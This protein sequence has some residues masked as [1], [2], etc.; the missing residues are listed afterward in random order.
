MKTSPDI[1]TILAECFFAL[2]QSIAG[3]RVT[4]EALAFWHRRYLERFSAALGSIDAGVWESDRRNV[5]AKSRTLGRKAAT[6]AALSGSGVIDVEHAAAASEA[7]DC[8]PKRDP[9]ERII[10]CEPVPSNR[11]CW[12]TPGLAR[13]ASH[14]SASRE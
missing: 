10:W 6:L 1:G 11:N 9:G 5:L 13:Q 4:P 8:R 12:F 7:N 3:H 14:C 2:G